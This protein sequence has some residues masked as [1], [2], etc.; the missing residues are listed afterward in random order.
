MFNFSIRKIETHLDTEA[1]VRRREQLEQSRVCLARR[2]IIKIVHLHGTSVMSVETNH[3][4]TN[5]VYYNNI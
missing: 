5:V 2:L 3:Y 1:I 4:I